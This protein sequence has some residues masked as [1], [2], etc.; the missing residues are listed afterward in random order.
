MP[1][2]SP[3]SPAPPWAEADRVWALAKDSTNIAVL[4]G[5]AARFK[6]TF[7]ADMARAR[8]EELK[9]QQVASATLPLSRLEMKLPA[10]FDESEFRVTKPGTRML[11]CDGSPTPEPVPIAFH[12]LA[13]L[14]LLKQSTATASSNFPG[15]PD[16]HQVKFLNDGW[17]NNCR[18]WIP[19]TL[20]AWA[21]IDLGAVYEIQ[22]VR[23]GSEHSVYWNDRS[24]SEFVIRLRS[25]ET[26]EWTIVHEHRS[27]AISVSDTQEFS[28]QPKN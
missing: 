28:F 22:M 19:A 9:K 16:R 1:T 4:E 10:G 26:S 12:G 24:P 18:S 23:I 11:R 6:D 20:P 27:D 25:D 8:I 2:A 15:A 3:S 17:Y 14:A 13:N 5:F 21:Q 7:Y